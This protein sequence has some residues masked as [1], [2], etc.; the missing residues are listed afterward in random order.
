MPTMVLRFPGGRYHATPGGHHVNEGLVEWPPSPWRLV[1]ALIACGYATQHW[2]EV[3]PEGRRLVECLSSVLPEYCLPKAALGHSRHYMPLGVLD[4]GREKTTLVLDTFADLADGELWVRWPVTIDREAQQ[5]FDVLVANL[6]YLG[7]SESW[8]LG[9]PVADDAKLPPG[10]RAF[11]HT[12]DAQPGRGCEQIALSAPDLP[13]VYSAW[14]AADVEVATQELQLP[15]GKKLTKAQQKQVDDIEG[16][17]PK[18]IINCLQCDTAWWKARK[19]SRAPGMRTVLYWREGNALEVGA[20][21]ASRTSSP[22][23]VEMMLLALTTPSGSKS[24]LPSV[25][26]T[27]PQADLVHKAAVSKLGHGGEPCPEIVGRDDAGQPLKGHQHAHI[28]PVDLDKDGHLDHVVLFAPMGLSG[29]AQQVVRRVR[30]VAMKGGVGELQVAIA[31]IGALDDLRQVGSVLSREIEELLGPPGGA[32]SWVS[33]TPFVPPR[34]LR[35]SGRSSLAG[36]VAEEL[37]GRGFPVASV[38]VLDWEGERL[39]LRHYVRRRTR[40]PQPP[41][42]AGYVLRLRFERPVAGPICLGYG[43]H[44]GMGRFGAEAG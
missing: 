15:S 9:E 20:V 37:S 23:R 21:S 44:F 32:T 14:R 1:R 24:A 26:R 6:G 33:K 2:D 19:W 31:G 5:L 27:L 13:E 35:R 40:G 43:S 42:D 38:Q 12:A 7:R 10:G 30:S 29:R 28:L 11:P 17:Y 34:Y 36:Q 3:P 39:K 25:V 8:V 41:M 4:Q 18:D 16:A 22:P